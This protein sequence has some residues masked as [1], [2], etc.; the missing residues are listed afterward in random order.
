MFQTTLNVYQNIKNSLVKL[1]IEKF[2]VKIVHET[3]TSNPLFF[4]VKGKM[5]MRKQDKKSLRFFKVLNP[6]NK[7]PLVKGLNKSKDDEGLDKFFSNYFTNALEFQ[8]V[9][10]GLSCVNEV[11]F[12]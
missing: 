9:L 12:K 2:D 5:S 10:S 11:S 8:K 3:A 1:T 7:T 4:C 6:T